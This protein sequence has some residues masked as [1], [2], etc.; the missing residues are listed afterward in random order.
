MKKLFLIDAMALIYRGHYGMVRSPYTTSREENISCLYS[1]INTIIKL[2]QEEKLTHII[3]A[4]DSPSPT[5]RHK[6]FP[7][8]KQQRTPP[9]EEMLEN[10]PRIEE[11]CDILSIQVEKVDGYEADDIVGT[12]AKKYQQRE[13]FEIFL[14]TTDKDFA[15]LVDK[16]TFIFN[17]ILK[18]K[19]NSIIS[20]QDIL[21]KWDISH[22]HQVRDILALWG[23]ASDNISG[24][25][26]IGEKRAKAIIKQFQTVENLLEN[27]NQL[28]KEKYKKLFSENRENILL[29]K[30]LV[31]IDEE[32]PVEFD[33]EKARFK[34]GENE[35]K[36]REFFSY[37]ELKPLENKFFSAPLSKQKNIDIPF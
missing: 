25:P 3:I 1:F 17:P 34:S 33:E 27:L 32:C 11:F 9:P 13:D 6:M 19:E 23:D 8:Y 15:Q 20:L 24:V 5:F 28:E 4:F 14:V 21:K 36:L 31:T 29:F 7:P 22:P 26:S 37:W 2:I 35:E 18:Q 10:I 30:K 12:L 16:R